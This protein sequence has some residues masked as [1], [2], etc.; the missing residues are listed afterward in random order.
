MRIMNT[1]LRYLLWFSVPIYFLSVNAAADVYITINSPDAFVISNQSSSDA[2]YVI[3]ETSSHEKNIKSRQ[4]QQLPYQKEVMSAAKATAIDPAL[5]HAIIAAESQHQANALSQKGAAGLM[6][7]MPETAKRFNIKNRYNPQQNIMA[8]SMYLNEL[9]KQFNGDLQLT[10]AAYNA[11][12]GSVKKYG[13]QIPPFSETQKYVPKVIKLY[14][15]FSK[16]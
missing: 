7:L 5:I 8:G 12:P 9:S 10:I 4:L 3:T 11:G 2:E 14:R 13:D 16:Q 6:Q 15:E 1:N